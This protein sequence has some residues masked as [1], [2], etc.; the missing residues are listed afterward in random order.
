MPRKAQAA[1]AGAPEPTGARAPE[2]SLALPELYLNRELTW[3]QFNRRVL[4]E[5]EDPR[6]PLLERVKF[7]AI[8][9]SNLDEF[10]MKRIGGLKQQVGAGLQH[11]T[12]D[13]RTPRQQIAECYAVVR[14]LAERKRRLFGELLGLLRDAGIRILGYSELS[15]KERKG[16]RQHYQR[17]IYPLVT[18]QSIDPAH[19]FPFISNLSLNLLVTLR[20]PRERETSLA[21]V[22]VPVGAGIPRFIRVG[23]DD[24]F[25]PLEEVMRHNLDMLFPEMEVTACELFRVTRNANTERN[26]EQADDLLSLI[27]SELQDRR[28]APIVRLEVGA[29]MDPV[30]RGMLAAEL[31]LTEADDVFDVDGMLAFRDLFEI[32]ALGYPELRDPP[33]HPVDHPRLMTDRNIFHVLRDAGAILL[34][35]PYDSFATSV[36]R[37]LMEASEDPKVRAIKMTL[38]RTASDSR[39][40]DC[41]VN[42]ANNGKQVAVAVELKARFD[43]AANIRLAERMEEAGIHV[44]YGVVGLKTHCKVI[45]VVRQDYNGLRRYVHIGTGNYHPGTARVYSDLGL[46]TSDETIGQDAT[47]LFNYL[48]T[49]YTPRRNYRKLLPAPKHLKRALLARIEREAELHS[50]KSPG[51]IQFKMNALEDAD[52]VAALYRAARRGVRIDLIIRDSCRLRPGVPGLSE[53]VRVVSVVGRFLEHARIY[54]FRNGGDEEYF[55]GSADAMKRNLEYRVEVLAP[56]EATEL[57]KE[58]RTMIDV[59]LGD[60]RSA[61]DMRP[62]GSYVQRMPGEGDDPRG[63]HEILVDLAEKRRKAGARL[64]KKKARGVVRRPVR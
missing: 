41:L 52:I 32:A 54:Y 2:T 40:I 51:L 61:W 4:H 19:P 36:E 25:V 20:Y 30:H 63:S 14:D 31:E 56:V 16:L 43:E 1:G 59:Q 33:H 35:H 48:T 44:T 29:D 22:K 62:D 23:D 5:A 60:R 24:R 37:F 27:E 64:K 13:G 3:L 21:R 12:V 15:E 28:F 46:L 50:E 18:P 7:T 53:S 11:P 26:E 42:A 6:T 17:N 38:Y 49:G 34:Q 9:S 57:R 39:I 10:F 47:E 55:V 58:L 8:V 45:L